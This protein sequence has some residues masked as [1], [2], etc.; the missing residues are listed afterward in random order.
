MGLFGFGK[1]KEA[2]TKST[3]CCSGGC[4]TQTESTEDA[5]VKIL[6]SGCANC[7]KLEEATLE[8]LE[9]LGMAKEVEHVSDFTKI[10]SFGVMSTPALVLDGK[11]LSAGKVLTAAEAKELLEKG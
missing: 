11:V 4:A 2:E 10:A 1:K 9:S 5:R 6:G 3:C 8:A 7:N